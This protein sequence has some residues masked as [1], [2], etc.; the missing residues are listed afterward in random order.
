[1]GDKM[2]A[3]HTPYR[4]FDVEYPPAALPVFLVPAIGNKGDS[5][6]YRHTF[7]TIM[8]GCGGALMVGL[9]TAL[10]GL[11]VSFRR[12]CGALALAAVAPILLGSVILTRFDLWPTA[13]TIG[14]LAALV[15]GRLRLGH[16]LLGLGVAA[17]LW[18]G[19]LVPLTVAHVWRT[20]GR[21][22]ALVS[23]GVALGVI[24][25][26]IVPFVVIA[27]DGVWRSLEGQATRPL[28]IESLGAALIIAAHHVAGTGPA[29]LT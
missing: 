25:L 11:G 29:V 14:A 18:P 10:A 27:P 2:A 19:V 28:E 1:L 26:G 23:L 20:R 4:D 7:E 13:L 12:F 22:E 16:G 21:R 3:R 15:W 8:A 17:K 24:A 6:A 5:D 9:A